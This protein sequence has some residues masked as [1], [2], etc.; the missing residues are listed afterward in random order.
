[1]HSLLDL[2][3][4]VDAFLFVRVLVLVF[5]VIVVNNLVDSAD[6]VYLYSACEITLNLTTSIHTT[7]LFDSLS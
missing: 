1:M 2:Y 4:P 3:S 6:G 7:R 5:D